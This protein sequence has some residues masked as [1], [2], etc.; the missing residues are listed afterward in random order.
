MVHADYTPLLLLL[1]LEM[2]ELLEMGLLLGLVQQERLLL[3]PTG[4]LRRRI[5]ERPKDGAGAGHELGQPERKTAADGAGAGIRQGQVGPVAVRR[6]WRW[7]W[8]LPWYLLGQ[9]TRRCRR[10]LLH[11]HLRLGQCRGGRHRRGLDPPS[12]LLLPLLGQEEGHVLG[13]PHGHRHGHLRTSRA[14]R[15]RKAT[16]MPQRGQHGR[17]GDGR[18][19][20]RVVPA[21]EQLLMLLL[22]LPSAA[23]NSSNVPM[24]AG[25]AGTFLLLVRHLFGDCAVP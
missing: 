24:M 10:P 9:R 3:L 20:G 15:K 18:S 6:R 25:L 5:V 1:L 17:G 21:V 14:R 8:H 12:R 23:G 19:S 13:L 11:L 2:E 4:Q 16:G 7:R 22:L